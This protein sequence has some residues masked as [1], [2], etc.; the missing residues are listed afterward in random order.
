MECD[1]QSW[2]AHLISLCNGQV[3][4]RDALRIL[5]EKSV[6]PKSTGEIEFAQAAASLVSGGF[7][8]VEGYRFVDTGKV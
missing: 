3:T 7:I 6:F 8:E 4:G 5:V 2:M 1:A